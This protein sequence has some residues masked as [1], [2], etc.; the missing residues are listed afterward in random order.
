MK[1]KQL[2]PIWSKA[3]DQWHRLNAH[4][5]EAI[6][7]DLRMHTRCVVGEAWQWKDDY[8]R[9][10]DLFCSEC[11]YYAYS[12][13]F[14]V[15]G[16]ENVLDKELLETKAREFCKHWSKCHILKKKKKKKKNTV[17]RSRR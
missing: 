16:P 12:F 8:A 3:F 5:R 14:V 13:F 11:D 9:R 7:Y 2:A 4:E 6:K 15:N 10:G 17:K 1:L